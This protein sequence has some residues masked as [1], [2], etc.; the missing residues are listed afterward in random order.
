MGFTICQHQWALISFP[1]PYICVPSKVCQPHHVTWGLH[2]PSVDAPVDV[3]GRSHNFLFFHPR[4]GFTGRSLGDHLTIVLLWCPLS[5]T[6]CRGS[7]AWGGAGTPVPCIMAAHTQGNANLWHDKKKSGFSGGLMIF[8]VGSSLCKRDMSVTIWCTTSQVS[9]S[10][11]SLI[12]LFP[13]KASAFTSMM[14]TRLQVHCAYFSVIV[15]FLFSAC[16][17]HWLGLY[18]L[19]RAVVNLSC[20]DAM[21]T[22]TC[23][24]EASLMG[25][26]LLSQWWGRQNEPGVWGLYPNI[27]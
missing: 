24:V 7:L 18:L 22:S 19:H 8:C 26:S 11:L 20:M 13:L 12:F 25:A 9:S 14:V 21:Y 27:K 2:P 5:F 3:H 17:L 1:L 4:E 16:F 23:L 10:H 15:P 6:S